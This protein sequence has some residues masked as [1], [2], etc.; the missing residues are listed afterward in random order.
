MNKTLILGMISLLTLGLVSC[1]SSAKDPYI[2]DNGNWWL[3]GR[4]L[5]IAVVDNAGKDGSTLLTGKGLPSS[6]Y[7]KEGDS[8]IDL[9]TWD[10]YLKTSVGWEKQGNIKEEPGSGKYDNEQ[11]LEFFL[12]DDGTYGVGG[13]TSC[14]LSEV[15]IPSVYKSRAVTRV[16]DYSF[17]YPYGVDTNALPKQRVV[18]PDTIVAIGDHAFYDSFLYEIVIPS[19]VQSI[20][21]AAFGYRLESLIYEGTV[22]DFAKIDFGYACLGNAADIDY[23]FAGKQYSVEDLMTNMSLFATV[24]SSDWYLVSDGAVEDKLAVPVDGSVYLYP[25]L[26]TELYGGIV[27]A[28]DDANFFT[29]SISD[30]SVIL[31]NDS[32]PVSGS[33]IILKANKVGSTTVTVSH[34]KFTKSFTVNV[35][36]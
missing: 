36:E 7:G 29:A 6:S 1:G 19:S 30:A 11:G 21:N 10:Y 16:M 31:V 5:G 18:L 33:L 9:N 12:L 27:Y 4:D 15:I 23:F 13:G 28:P 17:T 14:W 35:Q 24:Y 25:R 3:D 20:A 2:G 8:Y 22:D 34:G 26:E 32:E